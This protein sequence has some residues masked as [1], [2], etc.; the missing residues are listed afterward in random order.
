M[1][2][3]SI[4]QE[5]REIAQ[6]PLSFICQFQDIPYLLKSLQLLLFSCGKCLG[7]L[8]SFFNFHLFIIISVLRPPN[9]TA[10]LVGSLQIKRKP[11]KSE[12][13]VPEVSK[14]IEET[15]RTKP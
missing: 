5:K 1:G 6:T 13:N 12:K 15:N 4:V 8:I 14:Q 3:S 9:S 10:T 2:C 11:S 7:P